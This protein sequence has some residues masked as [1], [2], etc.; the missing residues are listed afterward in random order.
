MTLSCH[1][2]QNADER[3]IE[4]R[5]RVETISRMDATHGGWEYARTVP[6]A[7]S[8]SVEFLFDRTGYVRGVCDE[9]RRFLEGTQRSWLPGRNGKLWHA[10]GSARESS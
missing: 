3:D 6:R 8:W 9:L 1:I 5:F 2:C 4:R 7:A 10:S